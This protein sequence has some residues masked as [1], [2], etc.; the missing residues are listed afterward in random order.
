MPVAHL[1]DV[2]GDVSIGRKWHLSPEVLERPDS[3][4]I[5]IP[6]ET[7]VTAALDLAEQGACLNRPRTC[8]QRLEFSQLTPVERK[9]QQPRGSA[10]NSPEVH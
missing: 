9:D 5:V 2:G 6:A 8:K 7:C 10:D 4:E 1:V 3:R